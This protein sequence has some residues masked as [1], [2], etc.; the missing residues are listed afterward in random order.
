MHQTTHAPKRM[1]RDADV[2][3][4]VESPPPLHGKT[5]LLLAQKVNMGGAEPCPRGIPP[6]AWSIP[7]LH[8]AIRTDRFRHGFRHFNRHSAIFTANPPSK[9]R[10]PKSFSRGALISDETRARDSAFFFEK[11]VIPPCFPRKRSIPLS[12]PLFR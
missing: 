5:P 10:H 9:M 2:T 1:K 7:P 3:P 11:W 8:S 12:T 4:G 6:S